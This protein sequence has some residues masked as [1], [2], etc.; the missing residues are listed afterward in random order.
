MQFIHSKQL[1]KRISKNSEKRNREMDKDKDKSEKDKAK[2]M[3]RISDNKHTSD[4]NQ[5]T[6]EVVE[7]TFQRTRLIKRGAETNRGRF[8]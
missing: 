4:H 8:G 2:K 7:T 5:V 1:V 6:E 3:V